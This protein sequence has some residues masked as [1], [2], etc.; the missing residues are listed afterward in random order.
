LCRTSNCGRNLSLVSI[1]GNQESSP[2]GI[3]N[4]HLSQNLQSSISPSEGQNFYQS[5]K[6]SLFR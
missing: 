3:F 2:S 5:Q 4:R 1:K 6:I